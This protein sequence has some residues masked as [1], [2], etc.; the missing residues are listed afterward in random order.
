MFIYHVPDIVLLSLSSFIQL[1]KYL[2]RV[3]SGPAL[4]ISS[5]KY[6]ALSRIDRIPHWVMVKYGVQ[7]VSY[8]KIS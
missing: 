5:V 7:N 8:I 3:A 6:T 1:N 4:C 2:L